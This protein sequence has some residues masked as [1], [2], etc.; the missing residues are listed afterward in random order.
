MVYISC[1]QDKDKLQKQTLAKEILGVL[2][3]QDNTNRVKKVESSE[4]EK[5]FFERSVQLLSNL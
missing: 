5:T 4:L 1:N 2:P 3:K